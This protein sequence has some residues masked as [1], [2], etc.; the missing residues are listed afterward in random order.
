MKT[1]RIAAFTALFFL[2]PP[3]SFATGLVDN[4]CSG[5]ANCNDDH[6]INNDADA[7]A[8]AAA[9]ANGGSAVNTNVISNKA[10][11]GDAKIERGAVDVDVD[12]KN[13]NNNFNLT[14]LEVE[15]SGN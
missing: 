9:S 8:A 6:S 3:S 1:L 13:L 15:H 10:D 11:G 5:I 2:Y 14:H 12:T 4:S 7:S